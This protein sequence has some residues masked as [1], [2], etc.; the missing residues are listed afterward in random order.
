MLLLSETAPDR[1]A[2][3]ADSIRKTL[4]APLQ[5]AGEEFQLTASIG[6]A[7]LT[8]EHSAP[9]DIMRDAELAMIQAQRFG[10]NRIEPFR[11]AF[12][13]TKDEVTQLHEDLRHA[14]DKKQIEVLFQP[15]V[16]LEDRAVI[17]FEA[18]VRWNHPRLGV[19]SPGDFIPAAE[20]SGLIHELGSHVML[21]AAR[22]FAAIAQRSGENELFVSIN[23]SSRELLR[24]D[25]VNDVANVLKSTGISPWMMRIELTEGLVMENPVYSTEVLHRIKA[26]GVGLSMDDF[27]TGFSSLSYLM[28]FPFDT[29]KI[30][31]SFIHARDRKERLVV[32]R[33]IIAMAHGLNQKLIAEGVETETDVAELLQLGCEFGQGYLFGE[34]MPASA[35][36]LLVAEEYRLAGQ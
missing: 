25:I 20:R 27:G 22:Q 16:S 18:L 29:I 3:F 34:P 1:I 7:T 33:S 13:N 36:E 23:L 32:L 8:T 12:R 14:I 31:R 26:L 19:V 4:Q 6:I 2:A 28:R 10:G 21:S 5:F 15:I 9:A 24:H 17:G 35:A 30:D 11:P